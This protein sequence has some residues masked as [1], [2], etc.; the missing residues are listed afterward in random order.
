MSKR[1]ETRSKEAQAKLDQ[2]RV[3]KER[4]IAASKPDHAGMPEAQA[5]DLV[6]SHPLLHAVLFA[7]LIDGGPDEGATV[8]LWGKHNGLGGLLNVKPWGV[9]AF[10]DAGS[11]TEWLSMAEDMLGDPNAKWQR[12]GRRQRP[13][14]S[15]GRQKH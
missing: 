2:L 8:I 9:Q 10:I 3:L 1:I 11:L 15:Q 4:L 12:E 6:N 14:K 7:H 5:G 13:R